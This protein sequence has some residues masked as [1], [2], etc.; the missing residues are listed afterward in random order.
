[1]LTDDDE[2]LTILYGEDVSSEEAEK[3]EKQV[4]EK[5]PDLEIELY[6][7]KQPIYA[8]IFAIE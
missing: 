5:Y 2:I 4:N 7:G 1:M 3:L 6:E 8:Y